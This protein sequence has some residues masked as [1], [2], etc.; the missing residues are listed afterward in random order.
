MCISLSL[1]VLLLLRIN[2]LI[3]R[4]K[5]QT[6]TVHTMPFIS[7]G[8]VALSLEH[9][10]QMAPT[11]TTDDFRPRHPEAPVGMAGHSP[12]D[13]VEVRRPA[14]A[15]LEL[16]ACLVQRRITGGAGVDAGAG[17]VLVEFARVRG[18]GAL[19]AED[20]ELFWEDFVS[21]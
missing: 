20:A 1:P 17:H 4:P 11:I 12:W 7:R 6:N 5:I 16:V 10:A 19:F 13:G 21:I 2:R 14:A 9:M 15:G 8:I 3:L 18:F